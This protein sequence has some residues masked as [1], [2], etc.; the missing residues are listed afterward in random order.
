MRSEVL[1][2]YFV[3]RQFD[4][5]FFYYLTLM[6][7]YLELKCKHSQS[8]IDSINIEDGKNGSLIFKSLGGRSSSW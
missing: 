8:S 7:R 5:N 6:L 4:Y 2:V 1:I 3:A